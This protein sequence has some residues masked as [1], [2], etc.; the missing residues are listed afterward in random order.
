MRHGLDIR[1]TLFF[2]LYT[3]VMSSERFSVALDNGR[4]VKVSTWN[5]KPRLDCKERKVSEDKMIPTKNGISL[6][7]HQIK[8]FISILDSIQK[9]REGNREN[10][11]HL[12]YNAFCPREKGQYLC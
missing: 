8:I 9:T 12:G 6:K 5:G 3:S 11:W 10:K 4:Y 2:E 7:L 1:F